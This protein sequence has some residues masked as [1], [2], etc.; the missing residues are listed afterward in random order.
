M[1]KI[2]NPFGDRGGRLLSA[3]VEGI[4]ISMLPG[5]NRTVQD[6][7]AYRA[8]MLYP[9]LEIDG[10]EDAPAVETA[11]PQ[12]GGEKKKRRSFLNL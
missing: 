1:M 6:D 7:V 5:E 11:E 8:K 3:V 2:K 12:F 4:N 10:V 9:F